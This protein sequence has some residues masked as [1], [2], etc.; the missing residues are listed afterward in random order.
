[1][2]SQIRGT[3]WGTL[4][5]TAMI[6][7]L[8]ERCCQGTTQPRLPLKKNFVNLGSNLRLTFWTIAGILDLP[9]PAG[10]HSHRSSSPHKPH[11]QS[12]AR[13]GSCPYPERWSSRM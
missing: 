1:M 10:F 13:P 7:D 3:R 2:V 4:E 11:G 5:R 8:R 12:V 9:G 6:S